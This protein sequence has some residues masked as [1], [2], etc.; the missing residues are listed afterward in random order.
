MTSLETLTF[1]VLCLFTK[2]TLPD[3]FLCTINSLYS[4]L[5][6]LKVKKVYCTLMLAFF[7]FPSVQS[8]PKSVTNVY[9]D[10]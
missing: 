7:E 10:Y 4:N 5:A 9:C 3:V 2:A 6:F 8:V 1:S